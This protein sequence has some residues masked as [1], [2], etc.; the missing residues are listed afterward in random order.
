M[1]P[2]QKQID[3]VDA[4]T[5]VLDIDFPQSSSEFTKR[6]YSKFISEHID[7]FRQVV[8]DINDANDED[9]MMWFQMLNGD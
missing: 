9:E 1:S 4:I 2:T 3:L 7:A 5:E 8:D 6:I